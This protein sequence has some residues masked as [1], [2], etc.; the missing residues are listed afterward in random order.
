LAHPTPLKIGKYLKGIKAN[1]L[2]DN[3]INTQLQEEFQSKHAGVA[4]HLTG[5]SWR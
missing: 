2:A 4:A 1:L 5:E 3:K